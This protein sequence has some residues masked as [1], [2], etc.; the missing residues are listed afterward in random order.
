[1]SHEHVIFRNNTDRHTDKKEGSWK[2]GKEEIRGEHKNKGIQEKK[3]ESGE[4]CVC[5]CVVIPFTGHTHHTHHIVRV[6]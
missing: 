3:E 1:M 5:M 4:T 6:T 2:T